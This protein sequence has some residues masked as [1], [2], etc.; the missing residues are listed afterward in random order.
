MILLAAALTMSASSA[1]SQPGSCN[2][3]YG[4]CM[5]RC[6]GQGVASLQERCI[7]SCEAKNGQCYDR[8][9]G[10]RPSG[11]APQAIAPQPRGKA[12]D[13]MAKGKGAPAP[14]PEAEAPPPEAPAPK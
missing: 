5:G 11:A 9:Y 3:E 7:A 13:A 10:R 2:N 12:T 6:V 1:F 8:M 14:A 4:A